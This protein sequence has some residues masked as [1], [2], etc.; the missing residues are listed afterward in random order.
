MFAVTFEIPGLLGE[1]RWSWVSV[2]LYSWV[3]CDVEG[4]R[5]VGEAGVEDGLGRWS[6]RAP[7]LQARKAQGSSD[8]LACRGVP[9]GKVPSVMA[10]T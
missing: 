8:A 9:A 3:E 2:V 6:S 1:V 7:L 4:Q 10:H 5:A